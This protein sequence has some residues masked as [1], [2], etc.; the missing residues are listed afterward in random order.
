VALSTAEAEYISVGICCGQLLWMKQTLQDYGVKFKEIPLLRDK[1]KVPSRL[2]T[3]L[4][5]ILEPSLLIFGIIFLEI[6]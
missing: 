2:P 5:N 3:I 1:M 4:F 6:M